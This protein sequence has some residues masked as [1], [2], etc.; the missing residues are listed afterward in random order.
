VTFAGSFVDFVQDF[1][2]EP[3]SEMVVEDVKIVDL[4]IVKESFC[5]LGKEECSVSMFGY[6]ALIRT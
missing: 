5:F 6:I 1:D 4:Q 3:S 2:L